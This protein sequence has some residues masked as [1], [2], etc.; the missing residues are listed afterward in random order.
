MKG[1][2]NGVQPPAFSAITPAI[3]V[4]LEPYPI[5]MLQ[6]SKQIPLIT[7][8]TFPS[9]DYLACR[10]RPLLHVQL[11]QTTSQPSSIAQGN[12]NKWHKCT[13]PSPA[14]SY[15]PTPTV[16]QHHHRCCKDSCLRWCPPLLYF[17]FRGQLCGDTVWSCGPFP[18]DL[19][20]HCNQSSSSTA[21]C[22]P[23]T[24]CNLVTTVLPAA[25]F[26]PQDTVLLTWTLIIPIVISLL[27]SQSQLLTLA[28]LR[29][30]FQSTAGSR[31]GASEAETGP[32]QFLRTPSTTEKFSTC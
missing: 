31:T 25:H 10:T 24:V 27:L 23:R 17:H 5:N 3:I 9:Q 16:S 30:Q 13:A 7:S 19:P 22:E 28:L 6:H 29:W 21:A 14:I 12:A 20:N 4:Y 2:S 1:T 32:A 11:H 8:F 18:S 26:Q 15:I